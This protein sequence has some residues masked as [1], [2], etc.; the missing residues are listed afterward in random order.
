MEEKY[1]VYLH[2][3]KKTGLVVYCGKGSNS[4]YQDY[5]SR[6]ADHVFMMK[7]NQLEYD[8]VQYFANEIEAYNHEEKVTRMY[9]EINQCRFNIS[10]GRRTSEQTKDKLSKILK[11]KKRSN[12]TKERI[13]K[14]HARPLAKKVLLYKEGNLLKEFMS[15]REAGKYAV[16]NEICSYGWCGR[17]LKTG[18]DTKPTKNY[19]TGGY[20]FV[21]KNDTINKDKT[22]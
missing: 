9:K 3:D 21:Y 13:K 7:N 2:K 4:R 18:E 10:L 6:V 22:N 19:P 15:S 16:E 8:F 14:S 5:S 11:G 17:S 20:L 12:E 1:Y